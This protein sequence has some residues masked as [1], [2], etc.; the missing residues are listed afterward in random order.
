M[1]RLSEAEGRSPTWYRDMMHADHQLFLDAIASKRRLSVRF[2][3]KKGPNAGREMVRVCASLDF[4]PLRGSSDTEPRY[5]F[6]DL[7]GKRKPL[8]IPLLAEEILEMKL[9]EETF[10]PAAIITWAFKPNA[11]QIPRDWAEF[12]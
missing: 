11:W 5:Q 7:E 6:W 8:N 2:T 1:G 9:L 12:S 3:P 4:G 10:D